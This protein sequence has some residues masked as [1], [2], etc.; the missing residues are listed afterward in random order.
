MCLL[1]QQ[2]KFTARK[3]A[4]DRMGDNL[5]MC[6]CTSICN[7]RVHPIA[8]VCVY[9]CVHEEKRLSYFRFTAYCAES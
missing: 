6:F 5:H 3:M 9:A 4:V 2:E 7:V 8:R 1:D